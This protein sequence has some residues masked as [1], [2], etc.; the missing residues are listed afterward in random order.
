MRDLAHVPL[1]E[2]ARLVADG[3]VR[4]NGERYSWEAH[5]M[6]SRLTPVMDDAQA[7]AQVRESCHFTVDG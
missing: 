3:H 5:D 4:L 2:A 6:V 7:I 1:L